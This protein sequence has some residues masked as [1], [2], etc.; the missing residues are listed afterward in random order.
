MALAAIHTETNCGVWI[1]V[2]WAGNAYGLDPDLAASLAPIGG[3]VDGS[4]RR[5]LP[6]STFWG[7]AAERVRRIAAFSFARDGRVAAAL[8]GGGALR[9]SRADAAAIV[10]LVGEWP[11]AA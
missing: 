2:D 11:A 8:E 3:A 9:L 6:R 7:G 5:L 1:L 4:P 10:Q